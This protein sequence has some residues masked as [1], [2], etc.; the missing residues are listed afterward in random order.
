MGSRCIHKRNLA[1]NLGG[2]GRAGGIDHGYWELYF[3]G[4]SD[5]KEGRID[6]TKHIFFI[7]FFLFYLPLFNSVT[8]KLFLG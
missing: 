5:L 6:P 3:T 4:E 8:K 7:L 1:N 2:G